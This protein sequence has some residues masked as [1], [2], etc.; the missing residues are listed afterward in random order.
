M[1]RVAVIGAGLSGLI[2]ARALSNDVDLTLFEKSRGY[3]GRMAT[4]RHDRYR[5]DH[6]TQFFTAR[7]EAFADFLSPFID[8][9]VV[10]RWDARFVEFCGDQVSSHRTWG[11]E[12][13][14]YVGVPGMNA[15]GRA[16]GESLDVRLQTRVA[17]L[18]AVDGGWHL[19]D[20]Q[21]RDLGRFDWVACSIPAAQA[22]VLL[23]PSFAH[24]PALEA[25]DM[26]GCYALMLGF[27][28]PLPLDWDAALV[29]EASISWISVDSSK[30]GRDGY[31]VLVQASNRWAE[32]NMERD[33]ET[34]T[35]HMLAEVR[36]VTGQDLSNADYI[37]LHRWR[38][39][40]P[41]RQ[42]GPAS[43]IDTAQRL[44]VFGDW[45]I[46]GRVEA[47]YLSGLDAAERIRSL[48]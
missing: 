18:Q 17:T 23:P 30:P 39:A 27:D 7:T 31:C 37:S 16:L 40:N 20:D 25:R 28:R 36:R 6:G 43:L 14:H 12:P 38:Y 1:K 24:Y 21:G 3:G 41:Q 45:C 13:P 19:R 9:G 33:I 34:V 47:A 8:Q 10:A 11:T 42:D 5:F 29:R 4:R 48:L 15:L 32:A 26:P 22:A 2:F 35:A 46:H 44:A